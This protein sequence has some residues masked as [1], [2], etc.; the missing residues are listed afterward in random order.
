MNKSVTTGVPKGTNDCLYHHHLVVLAHYLF[1][2]K[3][4]IGG[5][6]RKLMH[7]VSFFLG[8]MKPNDLFLP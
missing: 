4:N 3:K 1:R 6:G 5:E 2:C 7:N 8:S